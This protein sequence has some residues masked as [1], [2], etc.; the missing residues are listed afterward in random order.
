MNTVFDAKRLI[1]RKFSDTTVKEDVKLWPFKV[2]S[3]PGD[4]PLISVKH[5]G[6][7]KKF[8]AEEISSMVLVK[9]KE[10][11]ETY[12]GN[13][14]KNAVVTVPAY[15]NDSQRQA[16]KDAGTIAGLNVQ[17]II[18]EPTAAAIAYGLDKKNQEERNVLIF[19]LG[20]GTF[21]VSLL[22]IDDGIFE[23]KATNGHTHLGGEDFDNILV[24]YCISLFK[25]NTNLDIRENARAMRRLRTQ[26]E[27]TKR[28]LS[29]AH[30][31]EIYCE[32]LAEGEDF[33]TSISRAKFEE[34]CLPLFRKCMPPVE[35]VLKDADMGKGQIHDIVLVGG[36]TRVPKIQAM[37]SEFFNG[38]NLNRSINPD[39]AVAYGAA[40]QAAIL[41]DGSASGSGKLK[42]LL[43]LDIAP[44]SQGIETAG[45]IMSNLI[46]RNT[47]IPTKKTQ[48]FTT[49][50]DNQPGV[51][52]QVFEGER[53]MTKD[54]H[55]LGSFNL[56]GIAPASRGTPQIEVSFDINAN[57]IL[58]VTAMD[59]ANGKQEKI[60][61]RA[62]SN[63]LTSEQIEK[64]V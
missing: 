21:D 63:R 4:K 48:I 39:E 12:L 3:G 17:R 14:V 1:G 8:Q 18:N 13:S 62:D 40:V 30:T 60:E 6:E 38:K 42:D 10:I 33:S 16:T 41:C 9:M 28:I 32:T 25:K 47:Q 54:N 44:L 11:A 2:V 50:V 64:M 24:E 49:A 61:I 5:I 22:T 55:K 56:E 23:V 37:L 57:G 45:G 15:F 7:E 19:D 51:Q 43:L 26:C 52:I 35:Q 31:S 27:K 29:S 36:S 53:P 58:N 59:K 34:L 46:P 20:G